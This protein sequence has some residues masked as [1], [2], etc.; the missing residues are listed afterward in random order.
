MQT[1]VF[2][3]VPLHDVDSLLFSYSSKYLA[4]VG[5]G[6]L[7]VIEMPTRWGKFSAYDG[8]SK[9]VLCKYVILI[10]FITVVPNQ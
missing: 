10:K 2:T 3:D 6:G 5:Q 4:L 7:S 9:E 1:F 8:G